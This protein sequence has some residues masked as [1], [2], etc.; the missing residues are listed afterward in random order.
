MQPSFSL[1]AIAGCDSM[2][3]NVGRFASGAN[4]NIGRFASGAVRRRN[5]LNSKHRVMGLNI[6]ALDQQVKLHKAEKDAALDEGAAMVKQWEN[7]NERLDKEALNESKENSDALLTL[8]QDW[9]FQKKPQNRL[10]ADLNPKLRRLTPINPDMCSVSAAQKF[11]GED[12]NFVARNR[13][14]KSQIHCWCSQVME[15]KKLAK[16]QAKEGE[17]QQLQIN[18]QM[19]DVRRSTELE[20]E[21]SCRREKEQTA[22]FNKLLAKE[23][24]AER[25]YQQLMDQKLNEWEIEGAYQDPMLAE[26]NFGRAQSQHYKGMSQE[27]VDVVFQFNSQQVEQKRTTRQRE[28]EAESLWA[29]NYANIDEELLKNEIEEAQENISKR[30]ELKNDHIY[31]RKEHYELENRMKDLIGRNSVDQAFHDQFGQ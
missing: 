29:Q 19:D 5:M 25:R 23:K 4:L 15:M 14:Q 21:M 28:Q 31:Q 26:V 18:K 7:V 30:V 8:M 11:E 13:S 6:D 9:H 10:E 22:E 12:L 3:P 2:S 20:T 24:R 27:E 17:K 1:P 16:I